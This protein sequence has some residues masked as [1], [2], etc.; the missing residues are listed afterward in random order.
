MSR[1]S[2]LQPNMSNKAA[3]FD[4]MSGPVETG[5]RSQFS[6]EGLVEALKGRDMAAWGNAPGMVTEYIK[7]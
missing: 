5:D 3:L 1:L 2:T 4:T 6:G 7:P